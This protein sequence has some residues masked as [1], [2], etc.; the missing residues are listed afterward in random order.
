MQYISPIQKVPLVQFTPAL[1]FKNYI[2]F[3]TFKTLVKQS[4]QEVL[5]NKKFS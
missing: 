1:K 4:F 3:I 2:Y 5:V